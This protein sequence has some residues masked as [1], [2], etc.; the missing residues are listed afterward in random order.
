MNEKLKILKMI[1]SGEISVEEG[2]GLLEA[3]EQTER[4]DEERYSEEI[5]ESVQE[6][7]DQN[8]SMN[9]NAKSEWLK[10]L[11]VNLV[12][13]RI[14]I[15]KSNVDDVVVE[16][17]HAKTRELISQ[18]EWLEITEAAE[19]IM[20]KEKRVSNLSDFINIFKDNNYDDNVLINLKLPMDVV[21]SNGEIS[22]VSG[23]INLIGLSCIDLLLK[24]VS[25]KCAISDVNA[26]TIQIKAVSGR[27][28]LDN[29]TASKGIIR[30]TSGKSK[31]R[32]MIHQF[33]LRTV[34]GS[35][36]IIFEG[37]P[38]HITVTST[39][40]KIDLKVQ[41]PEIYN[42]NFSSVSGKIDT[43]GFAK[44][45][46]GEHVGYNVLLSEPNRD[47][48][49]EGNSVSGKLTIDKLED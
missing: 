8:E 30:L 41:D 48:T 44:V 32:G 20:I 9:H 22:T 36:E 28:L 31:I 12:S 7:F 35:S 23:N 24:S 13:S 39:S 4:I 29:V 19:C 21:I 11:D 47:H 14:N 10:I 45:T 18:P 42:L 1:E 37:N 3:I 15:E 38:K 40:G 17:R 46:K 49:I 5:L 34:S 25:G 6:D 27:V 33:E 2:L 16:I 43:S 26:K